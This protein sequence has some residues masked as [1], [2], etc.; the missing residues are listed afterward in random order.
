[1]EVSAVVCKKAPTWCVTELS[2]TN[3]GPQTHLPET[4]DK[5]LLPGRKVE[6]RFRFLAPLDLT[7]CGCQSLIVIK[8]N[9]ATFLDVDDPCMRRHCPS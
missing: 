4:K 9:D 5:D 8:R 7:D 1:M 3:D 6:L 2:S